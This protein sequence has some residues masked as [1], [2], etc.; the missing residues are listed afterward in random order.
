MPTNQ[1]LVQLDACI[2]TIIFLI[3]LLEETLPEIA[4]PVRFRPIVTNLLQAKNNLQLLL[5]E[6]WRLHFEYIELSEYSPDE[7]EEEEDEEYYY[8][9]S[10]SPNPYE[11][12]PSDNLE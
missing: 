11:N 8:D 9:P 1:T 12:V 3:I 2:Q 7:D 5:T 10:E 4:E 6:A